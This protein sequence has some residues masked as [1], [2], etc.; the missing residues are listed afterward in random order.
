MLI[1]NEFNVDAAPDVVYALM[2]DVERVATCLPGTEVL[3]QRDDGAYDGQMKLKL[4]PMKMQYAGTVAITEQDPSARTAVMLASGTEAKGQGSAQGTLRMAVAE[5]AEGGSAVGVST[6]LKITG[7][8]AQMG[9]GIMQDVSTRM[10]GEMAQNM[11]RLLAGSDDEDN[12]AAAPDAGPVAAEQQRTMPAP[13]V[14]KS[15]EPARAASHVKLSTVVGAVLR[16]RLAALRS[17]IG[18]HVRRR[19]GTPAP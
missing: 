15:A 14:P 9:H 7:R 19:A 11:E 6:E 3:G 16:G 4:G 17:W 1:E 13:D 8:V 18:R 12:T 10:I 2:V 5:R